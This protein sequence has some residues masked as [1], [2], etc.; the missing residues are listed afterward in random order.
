MD[1]RKKKRK[2][3]KRRVINFI[4][5]L[6]FLI[7]ILG[8]FFSPYT[9]E[10]VAAYFE[11]PTI[12]KIRPTFLDEEYQKTILHCYGKIAAKLNDFL[13]FR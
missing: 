8:I 12:C 13:H 6:G 7:F 9:Y 11:D 5:V 2:T 4:V 3:I 10:F 1:K